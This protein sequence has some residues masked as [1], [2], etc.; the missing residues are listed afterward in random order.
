MA[1]K[2]D[3]RIWRNVAHTLVRKLRSVN[4]QRNIRRRAIY[5]ESKI[6]RSLSVAN[7]ILGMKLE[8]V[9]AFG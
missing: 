6:L 9:S 4:G 3:L 7:H 8:M 5:D 1:G 2:L